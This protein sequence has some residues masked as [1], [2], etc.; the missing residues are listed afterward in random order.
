VGVILPEGKVVLIPNTVAVVKGA[1]HAEAARM[2]VDYLLSA[3]VEKKLAE[4]PGAQVPL[5]DDLKSLKTKWEGLL[6]GNA[7]VELPVKEIAADR[8]KTIEMLRRVGMGQ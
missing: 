5:G 1:P 3:E 4:M 8:E 7:P 2:V 6:A